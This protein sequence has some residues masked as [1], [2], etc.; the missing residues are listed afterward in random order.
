V[1]IE[2]IP[3]LLPARSALAMSMA[4]HELTTNAVK[5][6]ALSVPDG[7]VSVAWRLI[8]GGQTLILEWIESG[9]PVVPS[10]PGSGFGRTLLER[11]LAHDLG[12]E[13]SLEF[14]P[15]GVS[16]RIIAPLAKPSSHERP[17]KSFVA[18]PSLS[19]TSS[20]SL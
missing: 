14:N 7:Q 16:C 1:T 15:A 20:S 2:G 8:G 12:G 11:G 10:E 18:A 17:W 5:Y 3:V 13:V 4:L 6:G 19:R 9:G